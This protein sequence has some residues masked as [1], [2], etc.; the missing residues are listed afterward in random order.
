[1]R[2]I[3]SNVKDNAFTIIG[4]FVVVCGIPLAA[5]IASARRCLT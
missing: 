4:A 3:P 1:M 5:L 2:L